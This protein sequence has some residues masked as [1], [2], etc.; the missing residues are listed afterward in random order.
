MNSIV[1]SCTTNKYLNPSY[2]HDWRSIKT[3]CI[4]LLKPWG[5]IGFVTI[6]LHRVLFFNIQEFYNKGGLPGVIG[7]IDEVQ[8]EIIS[9]GRSMGEVFRNRKSYFSINVLVVVDTRGRIL[10]IDVR[11][12]GFV[13][14]STYVDRSGFNIISI[15]HREE[16]NLVGDNGFACLPHL[17]T[18]FVSPAGEAQKLYNDCV[19]LTRN[20]VERI[21]GD[22]KQTFQCLKEM[23]LYY[24]DNTLSIICATAVLWNI[25]IQ[26]KLQIERDL[27]HTVFENERAINLGN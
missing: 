13:H 23:I 7:V 4:R 2:S 11:N 8:I 26:L 6:P 18:R 27:E 22:W 15:E 3:I 10:H 21:F 20:I 9:P 25:N 14:D 16:G 24:I 17:V 1:R 19:I 12:P 5:A